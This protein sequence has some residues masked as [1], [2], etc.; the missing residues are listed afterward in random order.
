MVARFV[1]AQQTKIGKN[2]LKWPQK[3][4]NGLEINQTFPSQGLQKYTHI[5]IF[6]MKIFHLATLHELCVRN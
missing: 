2:I 1:F 5:G 4:P 3:I 6:G